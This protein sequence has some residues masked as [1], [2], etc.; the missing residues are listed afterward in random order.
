MRTVIKLL[1]FFRILK[2]HFTVEITFVLLLA[3]S[4][5]GCSNEMSC[6]NEDPENHNQKENKPKSKSDCSKNK[7]F[8]LNYKSQLLCS[9]KSTEF[10]KY[11]F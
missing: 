3:Q 11:F 1:I 5:S 2:Q 8:G 9:K 7:K 10:V 4:K 6:K